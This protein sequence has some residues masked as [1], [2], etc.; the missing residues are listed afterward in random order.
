M[1]NKEKEESKKK[2]EIYAKKLIKSLGNS[3][4][5]K[6]R[7]FSG[8]PL[9]TRM[10]AEAFEKEVRIFCQ[11]SESVPE[12]PFKLELLELYGRF[13]E[14]KYDIYQDEKLQIRASNVAGKGQRERDLKILREDYQL[15][16]LKVLK[17]KKKATLFQNARECSFSTEDLTRI[18]IVQVSHDGKL[19][20]IHRT[21]AEYYVADCLVNRLTEVNNTSE[22]VLDFILKDI[23]MK[24]HC[25]VIRIFIDSLLSSSNLSDEV[26]KKCGNRINDF[27]DFAEVISH[28]AAC[29]GNAKIFGYLLDSAQAAGHTEAIRKL[30]LG[31]DKRRETAWK[32]AV[33]RG[34]VE[35][36]HKIWEWA[37]EILTTE[38]IQ[39]NLLLR[40]GREG[41]T[42]WHLA[43]CWD[44]QYLM[45][46]IWEWAKEKLTTE[47]IKN[48]MLLRTDRE[49]RTVWQLA[50]FQGKLD[51]MQKIWEWAKENLT[52]E[53]IK[54]NLLL[55]KDHKGR[56]AWHVAAY[57][58]KL[59]IMQ[60]IWEWAKENLTTEEI[61]NE[62]FLCTDIMGNTAWHLAVYWGDLDLMQKIWELTEAKLTREEIKNN[63]LLGT[64]CKGR[65]AWHL[66]ASFGKLVVMQKIWEWAEEKL[67]TEGLNMKCYYAQTVREGPPGTRQHPW[68]I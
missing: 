42:A 19:Q 44:K 40:N 1:D 23:C 18:G 3:I 45:Q 36:V 34:N 51:I 5:D 48:E 22:Q 46:I 6:D 4:S 54:N 55:H 64:D 14:R 63:L 41:R 68:A 24:Q 61:K 66:A 35:V 49:G 8:I 60:K 7:E 31:T 58:G 28:T 56:T 2:L 53:E 10:L 62:M 26:L 50:S 27:G 59:D 52:T 67:K 39:N 32:L 15:L 25:R 20:F 9:Q 43:A 37:Q 65:T 57:R 11:S 12:L 33:E 47:E 13:I 16:A 29:E 38:E 21:F 17:K 30:L